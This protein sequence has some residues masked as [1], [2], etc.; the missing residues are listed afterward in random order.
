[1]R[2]ERMLLSAI[3]LASGVALAVTLSRPHVARPS[4]R[5]DDVRPLSQWLA[6]HPADWVG[7]GLLSERAIESDGENRH[8]LWRAAFEHAR[9]LAPGRK[10]PAFAYVRAGLFNWH[11]LSADD[12][13]HVLEQAKPML[14]DEGVFNRIHESMFAVSG[15]IDFLLRNNPGT[16]NSLAAIASLALRHGHFERYQVARDAADARRLAEIKG[17]RS[18]RQPAELLML[19]PSPLGAE[20]RAMVASVLDELQHRPIDTTTARADLTSDLIDYSI[21]HAIRPLDG[22]RHVIHDVPSATEQARARLALALGQLDE[23]ER[24]RGSS[25]SRGFEWNQYHLER[26]HALLAKGDVKAARAS[27]GAASD[28][29]TPEMLATA[30]SVARADGDQRAEA[31]F[32]ERLRA[33]ERPR[34]EGLCGSEL[35]RVATASIYR[36]TPGAI[37]IRLAGTTDQKVW[38]EV[39][40]NDERIT[41]GRVDGG[42]WQIPLKAGVQKVEVRILNPGGQARVR[43]S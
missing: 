2:R 37:A 31:A 40:V 34:W 41:A 4:P 33:F 42:I 38:T 20:H 25:A 3:A 12:R 29:L 11:E 15:D 1:M 8:Q 10:Q 43:I 35:C 36:P 19:L 14:R 6:A 21:R 28:T 24:I 16:S 17:T 13:R 5:P 32:L 26:A 27:V 39:R 23:A 30:A 18:T 9:W 22:L 7:F